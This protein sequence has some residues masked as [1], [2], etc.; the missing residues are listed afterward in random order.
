MGDVR[1]GAVGVDLGE[2]LPDVDRPAAAVAGD[3][4]RAALADVVL[5]GAGLVGDDRLVAVVVEVDEAG[6]D[7]QAGAVDRLADLAGRELADGDDPIAAD[8]HVARDGGRTC[9]VENLSAAEEEIGVDRRGGVL[10]ER[11]GLTQRRKRKEEE[12][13]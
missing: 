8:G 12:K 3:E 6:G 11:I 7:D 10:G 2:I 13:E 4:R 1:A 5:R 9:A